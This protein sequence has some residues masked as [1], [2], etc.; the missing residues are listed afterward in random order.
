MPSSTSSS[1][2]PPPPD[3]YY[4]ES[5]SR[6]PEDQRLVIAVESRSSG[7]SCMN[8][9]LVTPADDPIVPSLLTALRARTSPGTR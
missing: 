6:R 3:P 5:A 7:S 9:F 2:T 8:E 1:E 4:E